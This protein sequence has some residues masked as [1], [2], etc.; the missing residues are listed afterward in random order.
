MGSEDYH[1]PVQRASL[2]LAATVVAL[3]LPGCASAEPAPSPTAPASSSAAAIPAGESGTFSNLVDVG[4]WEEVRQALSAAGV[5]DDALQEFSD[6]VHRFNDAVPTASLVQTGFEP[7]SAA[8]GVDIEAV[9]GAAQSK[10]MPLTNCRITTFTLARGFVSVSGPSAVD[11]SHLFL[12]NESIDGEAPIF[13]DADREAF[14]TLFGKVPT[15]ADKDSEQH[16]ADIQQ[17]FHD[18]GITFADGP[19]SMVSVFVHDNLDAQAYEFIGHVG[20]LLE[21]SGKLLFVEKLA[22]DEPY[23]AVWFDTRA[24]L[25]DYLMGKYDDGPDVEYGRALVLENDQL[26]EGYRTIDG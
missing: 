2:I 10:A 21:T 22:F 24:E 25:S 9:A 1:R 4:S 19:A 17:Y 11:D 6:Q 8:E 23:Q 15:T 7:L 3:L 14:R 26:I 18:H 5:A 20:I 13:I 16:L 12:D